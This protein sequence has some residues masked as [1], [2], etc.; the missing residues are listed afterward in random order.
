MSITPEIKFLDRDPPNLDVGEVR[1]VVERCF[2]LRGDLRPLSSE[3]DQNFR[4][5][6]DDGSRYVFKIANRGESVGVVDFQL[7]ALRHIAA[8][9]PS[10][11]V[12]R[13]HATLR[14][15]DF[16]QVTFSTGDNHIVYLLSYLDGMP[17]EDTAEANC[18]AM[19]R[20]VGALMAQ[21]DIALQGYF[22]PDA[23]QQ[24][25]WN[26]ETCVR[27]APLTRHIPDAM[28]RALINEVFDHMAVTVA[29]R[30]QRLRHQVIHQDAHT[31]NILVDPQD[32]HRITGLI[33][34]GDLLYGTLAAEVAVACDSIPREVEDIVTP[35]CE[36]AAGFDAELPLRA[37]EIDSI[38]DLLCA[39]A[40]LVATIIAARAALT[41]NDA[42]YIDLAQSSIAH[43][44]R[45]RAVGHSEFN[46]RLRKACRFPVS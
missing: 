31:N 25:P 2:G 44:R 7:G 5:D 16:E 37:D 6:A 45:L 4:V 27:L 24:H 43:L 17:I 1:D 20:R 28:D 12:P 26:V 42:G 41:P 40:A 32:D 34:F 23:L 33:D 19:R 8:V 36:I 38:Y 18:T 29:P 46:R 10:L 30:L 22:H 35:V 39:R 3:R 14:D 13:I 11:P 21:V 9:N 15:A